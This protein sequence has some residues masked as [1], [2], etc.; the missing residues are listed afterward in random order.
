MKTMRHVLV[1]GSGFAVGL[2]VFA[3][4]T[5]LAGGISR[6]TSDR[7][8]NAFETEGAV[9]REYA[10]LSKLRDDSD[11]IVVAT[12]QS[13]SLSRQWTA[14]EELGEDGIATYVLTQLLVEELLQGE[15]SLSPQGSIDMEIFLPSPTLLESALESKPEE[16]AVYF[17]QEK[18]DVP[19]TYMLSSP[20]AYLRDLGTVGIPADSQDPWMKDLAESTFEEFVNTLR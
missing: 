16:R 9:A 1:I 5:N 7:F 2:L 11:V 20:Q 14:V 4:V 6:P 15:P 18:A 8:W 19:G 12:V 3:S 13:V 10:S 17:L